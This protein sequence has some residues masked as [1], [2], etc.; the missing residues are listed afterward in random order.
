VLSV[1]LCALIHVCALQEDF[2][3]FD[4]ELSKEEMAKLTGATSP[5]ETGTPQNPDDAQD[6]AIV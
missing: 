3:L 2:D 4:F 5:P 6:C 1:L